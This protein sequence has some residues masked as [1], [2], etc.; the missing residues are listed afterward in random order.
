MAAKVDIANMALSHLAVGKT[1]AN[2]ET[3]TANEATVVRRFYEIARQATLRDFPWPFATR[4]TALA[5]IEEEPNTEW[6][7]S[8]R[9]PTDC[10]YLRR[11]LSG[12][13]NDSRQSRSPYKIASDS[14]GALIFSDEEDAEIEYTL[15][16]S[17]PQFYTPD[18][19]LAFSYYL[20]A[21]I[22]PELTGGDQFKL[23]ER[24]LQMYRFEISRAVSRA[25]NEEQPEE[26]VE[27]E[28]I[29]GRT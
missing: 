14:Q 15:D 28:F 17:Q 2:V 25:S 19:V 5:L 9:Y 20:A 6:G 24:A 18:F 21:L 10:V 7:Y 26:D 29:R 13:R 16:S 27:S 23:G 1:I 11:I 12:I 4:I 8:Y 3:D 22:G